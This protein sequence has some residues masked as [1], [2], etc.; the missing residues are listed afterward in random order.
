M[1]ENILNKF[2]YYKVNSKKQYQE[3]KYA[4]PANPK[5]N[6][7]RLLESM[8]DGHRF[9][10]EKSKKDYE[11]IG[12]FFTLILLIEYKIDQLLINFDPEIKLKMFGR[13]IEVFKDFLKV[14]E[15]EESENMQEYKNLIS[16]L[17]EIRKIRN[18][19]AH[20]LSKSKF[21]YSDI[22]QI[23]SYTQKI[24]PDLFEKLNNCKDQQEKCIVLIGIFGFVFADK[25][26]KLRSSLTQ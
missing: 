20:D 1:I 22:K 12:I 15:P 17:H 4:T 16:P 2:G 3:I 10:H 19:I 7:K 18:D 5:E 11:L 23:E 26:A 14:Y 24:R 9:I 13:K 25:I 8:V 6:N 21:D